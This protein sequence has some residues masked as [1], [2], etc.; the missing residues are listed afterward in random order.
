MK[1]IVVGMVLAGLALGGPALAGDDAAKPKAEKGAALAPDAPVAVVNGQPVTKAEFD[2]AMSAYLR[3][4]RQLTG[5]M[6]GGVSQPNEKM[7]EDVLRQLVDR[8]LLYQ[9][10]KKK[11]VD[12]LDAKVAEEL[13]GIKGRF[14]DEATYQK[15]L[16][17][18]QLTEDS[19][20]D[21]IAQQVL[22]RHYVETEIQPSVKVSDDE[23]K[24]FYEDNQDKFATPE[25]VR[26]SHI[27]IRTDPSASEADRKA[28]REKAEAL[29]KRAA[30]GEDF[31]T[32]AKENS[33][34]PG[35]APNGGDLGFF[36]RDRMVKPFADAAFALEKGKVSDVVETRFGYHVIKV[37][38]RKEATQQKFEDVKE[39][40]AQYLKA[41]A[42][43]QAVQA[44]LA[45]LRKSAKVD[46]VASPL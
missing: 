14:P 13:K 38:D 10:A 16:E 37:T 27:L 5:G 20:K 26:A 32:L 42:L 18:E 39:S 30:A 35:S 28:A 31:A 12:D 11:P 45:E 7:K 8:T 19:L 1:R 43:D 25:Q 3:R 17:S 29:R 2:R 40:I 15:A 6:H 33:E 22:V 34:D 44:K 21:L 4:F 23:V 46:V 36:T 9:E 24:K 41:R